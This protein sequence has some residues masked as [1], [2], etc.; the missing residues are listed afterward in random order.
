MS[1]EWWG[2]VDSTA[3]ALADVV[4]HEAGHTYGL[5]HVDTVMDGVALPESMGLRYS[6]PD[7][8]LWVQDTSFMDLP[9]SQWQC[10]H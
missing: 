4:L 3:L 9:G 5:F 10:C 2:S 8:A 1:D 7:K 6:E